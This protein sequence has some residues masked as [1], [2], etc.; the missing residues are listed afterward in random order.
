M[1]I[2]AHVHIYENI[3]GYGG[4]GELRPIGH[5]RGR[6]ANGDIVQLIPEGLGETGFRVETLIDLMDQNDI[7][8]A[9]V[10]QGNLYG[11]Q[12]EYVLE[13]MK[14]YPGRLYGACAVDPFALQAAALLEVLL[15]KGYVAAKFECSDGCGLMSFH[16]RFALDGSLMEP[17]YEIIENAQA[18]LVL[19]IGSRGMNSYHPEAVARI[20]GRH[21]KLRIVI[22]HLMAHKKG[23]Q[24]FLREELQLLKLPN[25]WFDISAVPWNT[26]PSSY[27]FQEAQEYVKLAKD[28]VG[29]EKLIWGSDA[30]GVAIYDSYDKLYSYLQEKL[31][32]EE[33]EKI[34]CKNAADAYQL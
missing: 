18:A 20:A 11:F 30:P 9:V 21:P 3:N 7:S 4:R 32:S 13:S 5:G 10:L 34:F 31:T 26:M 19:D 24:A 14:R 17:L 27:P 23:E 16:S 33:E 25:I 2:D 15:K 12:N 22:C 8:K 28:I 1:K 6:W 29:C